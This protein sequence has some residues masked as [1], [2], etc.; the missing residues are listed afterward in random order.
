[1]KVTGWTV[2][3]GGS[4]VECYGRERIRLPVS[5]FRG[6]GKQE[7]GRGAVQKKTGKAQTTV[8]DTIGYKKK[9]KERPSL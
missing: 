1:V 6:G 7:S 5:K 4:K 8:V 3:K 2:S 9:S